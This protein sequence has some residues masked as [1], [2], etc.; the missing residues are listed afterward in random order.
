M[1]RV[2]ARFEDGFV[3]ELIYLENFPPEIYYSSRP[4]YYHYGV[5]NKIELSETHRE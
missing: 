4:H 1:D 3:I 2:F 5:G